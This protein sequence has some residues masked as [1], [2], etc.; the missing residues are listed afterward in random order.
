MKAARIRSGPPPLTTRR[1]DAFTAR[2]IRLLKAADRHGKVWLR[3][4]AEGVGKDLEAAYCLQRFGYLWPT[5]EDKPDFGGNDRAFGWKIT[6][7]GR[8]AFR[9][10]STSSEAA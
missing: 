4:H 1:V 9:R 8:E 3:L 2:E 5:V 6:E 7:E 10:I